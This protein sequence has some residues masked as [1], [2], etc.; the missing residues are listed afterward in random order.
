VT[1][2]EQV[3]RDTDTDSLADSKEYKTIASHFPAQTSMIGY[4]N[5][6]SQLQ[7]VYELF[8]SG[9]ASGFLGGLDIDFSKLPPFETIE[10]YLPASGSY[11]VPD[12]RGALFVSFSL[13][14]Q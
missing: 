1:L 8:R 7:A 2:L 10:K 13:P 11:A 12:E 6:S 3:I 4:Q 5:Q 9:G 14:N